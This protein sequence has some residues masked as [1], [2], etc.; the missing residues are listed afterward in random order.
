MFPGRQAVTRLLAGNTAT[1]LGAGAW[2]VMAVAGLAILAA[3][4]LQPGKAAEIHTAWPESAGFPRDTG[5]PTLVM[6]AHPGCPCT[7]ASLRE[8]ERIQGETD[9]RLTA[10]VIFLAGDGLVDANSASVAMARAIR[11][12]QVHVDATAEEASRW[13]ARTSGQVFLYSADGRLRFSGG[14][15]PSR[16]HEGLN[17]GHSAIVS[18]VRTGR[19]AMDRAPVFGCSLLG[20]S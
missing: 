20:A 14:I 9:G 3:H 4:Q 13:G 12:V 19:L 5:R 11:G 7:R 18:F 1:A 16:G 10:H 15:T 6:L 17:T 8:L 2:A